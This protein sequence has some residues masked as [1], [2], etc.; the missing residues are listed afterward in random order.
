MKP[1]F[2][3]IF[4]GKTFPFT[5]LAKCENHHEMITQYGYCLLYKHWGGGSLLWWNSTRL[6]DG[7]RVPHGTMCWVRCRQ[8]AMHRS[9]CLCTYRR[10]SVCFNTDNSLLVVANSLRMNCSWKNKQEWVCSIFVDDIM[11]LPCNIWYQA[12]HY[13]TPLLHVY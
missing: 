3:Y 8:V 9:S 12:F 13:Y 5:S 11:N 6:L 10:A 2:L 4:R 7:R 1:R